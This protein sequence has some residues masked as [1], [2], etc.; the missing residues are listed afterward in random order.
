[1]PAGIA[2]TVQV[3]MVWLALTPPIPLV[4]EVHEEAAPLIFHETVPAGAVAP[5]IPLTV[6]V[7][8]IDPPKTGEAGEV[9]IAIV[10]VALVTTT[11]S[12]GVEEVAE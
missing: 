4:L 1:V 6:A 12:G 9:V 11:E 8:V 7:K 3:K 5:T 10:G 2:V